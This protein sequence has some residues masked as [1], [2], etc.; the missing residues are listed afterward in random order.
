[1]RKQKRW[2]F[3]LITVVILLTIYNILP[4]VLFYTKPLKNPILEKQAL[5]IAKTAVERVNSLEE[6]SKNWLQS[7]N[8]LL[9]IKAS[10]IELN[11]KNPQLIHLNFPTEKQADTFKK[12]LREMGVKGAWIVAYKDGKRVPIKDVLEGVI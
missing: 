9:D 1:M 11:T 6:Q 3:T 10:S 4:T 12:Y 7:F 8:Q 2:Q 5:T